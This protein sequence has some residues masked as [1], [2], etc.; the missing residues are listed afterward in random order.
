MKRRVL[1]ILSGL[2]LLWLGYT[3]YD[4]VAFGRQTTEE[5][6]D[7]AIVLGA[8][9]NSKGPT[10]VFRERIHHA[11]ALYQAGRVGKLVL[12][13]GIGE[14]MGQAESESA[15]QYAIKHGVPA[16][17][18]YIETVSHTTKENLLEAQKLM[19]QHQLKSALIVSDPLH[20]KR[21][22]VMAENLGLAAH[23]SPTPTT[24]FQSTSTQLPFLLHEMYFLQ[25]YRLFGE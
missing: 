2:L 17:N 5:N 14:G 25:H 23:S 7:A 16:G 1:V 12:T 11:I 3:A 4:I 10:P 6:A 20:M 21:A 13:G 18:I 8:A 24:M 15:R 9:I 19:R 22:M